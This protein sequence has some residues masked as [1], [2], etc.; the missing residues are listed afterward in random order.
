MKQSTVFF[1]VALSG[2]TRFVSLFIGVIASIFFN[3]CSTLIATYDA[4]AFTQTIDIKVET[5]FLMEKATESYADHK[6]EA[7]EVLKH[8]AVSYTHLTLPTILLV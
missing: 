3:S 1:P 8:I 4:Y 7:E 5:I 2:R 6:K